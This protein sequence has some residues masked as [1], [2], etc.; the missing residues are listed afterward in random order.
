M[1]VVTAV[2]FGL[3]RDFARSS[4]QRIYAAAISSAEPADRGSLDQ[5]SLLQWTTTPSIKAPASAMPLSC[6]PGPA[7]PASSW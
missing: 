1:L 3:G 7:R 4:N 2:G 6:A 5:A